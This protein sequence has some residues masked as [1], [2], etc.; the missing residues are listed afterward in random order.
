MR[1]RVFI[2][3]SNEGVKE[4]QRRDYLENSFQKGLVRMIFIVEKKEIVEP[5]LKKRTIVNVEKI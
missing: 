2:D 1:R 5:N 4:G 3:E